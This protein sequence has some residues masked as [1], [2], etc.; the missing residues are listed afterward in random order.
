[1]E[2]VLNRRALEL[3]MIRRIA[4]PLA[5]TIACAVLALVATGA[6]AQ[7][8]VGF[9]LVLVD[10][11]GTKKVL[12]RLP[13]SV[14]APRLSP[15][16][17][18][19][20]FETRDPSGPDGGR[21]W[22]AE[23]SDLSSRRP[24]TST[25]GPLDWAPMWTLDGER[26]V[27]IASSKGGDAVYWRRADGTGTPEKLLD[28]RSA[29]GW[30]PGGKQMRFLTLKEGS[31]GPDYDI[32]VLDIS[33]RAITPLVGAANSAEH[34]SA[35]SPDGRWLAYASNETGRYE[36]WLEP[37][38]RTG[39]RHQLTRDGGSHPLW[40]PDGRSLYFDRGQQMFQLTVN[41]A[42]PSSTVDPVA[43]PIKGFAQAE[44]RRQ[45]DLMPNGRQF[46]MLFPVMAE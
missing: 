4:R 13:A 3:T 16:A 42:A 14:Y 19:I 34:S 23:L 21:L 31:R 33:S 43:L 12:G 15:D 20:A 10:V 40:L 44:Y 39:A 2:H 1:M 41:L 29:E 17:K 32:A 36:V 18:R 9:D 30:M 26:L 7:R 5:T 46:L 35:V 38:P 28:A 27:F 25:V 6:G 22:I 45:F 37:L 24:I 8:P 11:D